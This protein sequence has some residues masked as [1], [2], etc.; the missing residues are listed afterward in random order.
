MSKKILVVSIILVIMLTAAVSA[1]VDA[2]G[3]PA[4]TK[5]FTS[6]YIGS[7]GQEAVYNFPQIAA[8]RYGPVNLTAGSSTFK[9]INFGGSFSG[10]PAV[11]ASLEVRYPGDINTIYSI[12][13]DKGYVT[14]SYADVRITTHAGS[15]TEAYIDWIAI[16]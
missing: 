14:N 13:L 11:V 12:G 2:K 3:K 15:L 9:R 8:G 10:Q 7:S 16:R 5:P 6:T 4:K 1:A